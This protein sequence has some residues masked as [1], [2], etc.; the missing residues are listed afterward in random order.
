M[1]CTSFCVCQKQV[2]IGGANYKASNVPNEES[3]GLPEWMNSK[4]AFY[5][6]VIRP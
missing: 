4:K 3:Q 2:H 5:I 1:V 6:M